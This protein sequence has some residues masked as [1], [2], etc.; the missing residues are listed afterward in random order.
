MGLKVKTTFEWLFKQA[1]DLAFFMVITTPIY[2][3]SR[4]FG[5]HTAGWLAGLVAGVIIETIDRHYSKKKN[6]YFIRFKVTG[7]GEPDVRMTQVL[8]LGH[9]L[10]DT[11]HVRLLEQAISEQ[12]KHDVEVLNIT[13]L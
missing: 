8:S 5:S 12:L 13:K 2:L 3:V 4:E 9:D 6:H 11:K 7:K 1:K 10:K